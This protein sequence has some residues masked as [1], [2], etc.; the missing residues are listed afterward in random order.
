MITAHVFISPINLPRQIAVFDDLTEAGAYLRRH[1]S[2][3]HLVFTGSS[4]GDIR[5][6]AESDWR[7]NRQTYESFFEL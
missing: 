6:Q 4:I 7:K 5:Q 1:R 2:M 3:N